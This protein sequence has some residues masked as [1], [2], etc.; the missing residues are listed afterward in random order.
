MLPA[1]GI[2]LLLV[3]PIVVFIARRP[4]DPL[5]WVPA[6]SPLDPPALVAHFAGSIPLAVVSLV[7]LAVSATFALRTLREHGRSAQ[8]WRQGLLWLWLT[9]PPLLTAVVSLAH[10]LW[11]PRYL[12]VSLPPFLALVVIG[13][14]RLR[15]PARAGTLLLLAALAV[16]ALSTYYLPRDKNGED[17][18][19]ATAHVYSRLQPNDVIWFAASGRPPFAYYAW[20][21]A[22]PPVA[23]LS[24]APGGQSG[25]IH[26]AQ[27]PTA[28]ITARLD[29][30]DRVWVVLR[31][32]RGRAD[33]ATVARRLEVLRRA[34]FSGDDVRAF[35]TAIEVQL[36]SR[37]DAR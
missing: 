37:D 20:K 12:I 4:G 33:D 24:L 7:L 3:A 13:L 5:S 15:Q 9:L 27:V 18:R 1:T 11:V 8:A 34:G 6:L 14:T 31:D 29:G 28:Q 30:H 36:W 22:R 19:A 23:D 21:Q 25:R 26:A 32:R 35:G 10:P 2:V 16:I 17:W